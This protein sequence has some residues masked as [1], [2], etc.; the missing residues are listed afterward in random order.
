MEDCN[1]G[2][3]RLEPRALDRAEIAVDQKR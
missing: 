2:S 3:E 1:V